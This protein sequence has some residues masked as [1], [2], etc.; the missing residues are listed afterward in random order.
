MDKQKQADIASAKVM[1]FIH[2]D[3]PVRA[4][5]ELDKF[6]SSGFPLTNNLKT[7]ADWIS[8]YQADA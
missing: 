6:L 2:R 1:M 5:I 8:W 7:I 4:Q 3:D